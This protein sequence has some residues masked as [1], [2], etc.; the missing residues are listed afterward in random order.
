MQLLLAATSMPFVYDPVTINGVTYRDGGIYDN[1]PLRP[2]IEDDIKQKI[3][4]AQNDP[5]VKKASEK[6]AGK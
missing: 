3:K 2:L 1:L 6:F 5:K 4:D